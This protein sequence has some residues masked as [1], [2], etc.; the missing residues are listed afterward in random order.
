[1]LDTHDTQRKYSHTLL[2][3]LVHLTCLD[4]GVTTYAVHPG[5]VNTDLQRHMDDA[6][7][8]GLSMMTRFVATLLFK[9]PEE[10]AQTSIYCSVDENQQNKTGLYYRWGHLHYISGTKFVNEESL[11]HLRFSYV[12]SIILWKFVEV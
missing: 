1:M 10:G 7:F 4:T 2:H 12:A 8:V 9:S 5:L 6:Y 11:E 3:T